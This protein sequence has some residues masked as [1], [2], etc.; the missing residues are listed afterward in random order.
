MLL[1]QGV[2]GDGTD[3]HGY[4]LLVYQYELLT[5]RERE[6]RPTTHYYSQYNKNV[7][8][9]STRVLPFAPPKKHTRAILNAESI[10]KTMWLLNE[11]IRPDLVPTF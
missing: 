3:A 4:T 1:P 11:K 9:N 6:S 5:E 2:A 10:R 8:I 7:C